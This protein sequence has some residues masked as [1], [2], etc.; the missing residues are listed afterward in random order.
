M[1]TVGAEAWLASATVSLAR[2]HALGGT[3]PAG[4]VCPRPRWWQVCTVSEGLQP[5]HQLAVHGICADQPLGWL[6]QVAGPDEHGA[7]LPP[8]QPPVA[9]HEALEGG[10]PPFHGGGEDVH[11]G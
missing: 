5:R 9:A 11:G 10:P 8:A 2:G 4:V 7:V 3:R 6:W 1:S